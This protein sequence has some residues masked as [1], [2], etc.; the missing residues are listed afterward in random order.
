MFFVLHHDATATR[1]GA[2]LLL[3]AVL[4]SA[5]TAEITPSDGR[6]SDGIRLDRSAAP[7]VKDADMPRHKDSAAD[8]VG[9]TFGVG[10]EQL[11]LVQLSAEVVGSDFVVALGFHTAV[12]APDSGQGNALDGYIDLDLDQDGTT[13]RVPW[14]DLLRADDGTTGMGNE[15]YVDLRPYDESGN[16]ELI[17]DGDGSVLGRVPL[18]L[19]DTSAR[20]LIPLDLLGGDRSIDVAAVVGPP[21]EA[22]DIAPNDGS[23]ASSDGEST[24]LLQDDRFRVDVDW[25][26]ADGTGIGRVVEQS[27]DSAVFYFFSPAN[28]ELLVKVLDSCSINDQVWVFISGSTDV[29]F[30]VEITDTVTGQ[31]RTYGNPAGRIAVT[32]T[33]TEAFDAC[34]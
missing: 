11:D 2:V 7:V 30:S 8:P 9:D 31:S 24:V 19:G 3:S 17:D 6:W 1:L 33:D 23:V 10:A 16:V 4:G 5:A 20:V 28:W 13:G 21:A 34:P 12:A 14:T 22:T 27:N 18:V 32:V 26:T 25:S 29:E 15:A